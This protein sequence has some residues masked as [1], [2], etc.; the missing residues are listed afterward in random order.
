M[1]TCKNC[2][3]LQKRINELE[4]ENKKLHHAIDMDYPILHETVVDLSHVLGKINFFDLESFILFMKRAKKFSSILAD[5]AI[6]DLKSKRAR[7]EA[8]GGKEPDFE[9]LDIPFL[10][11]INR[12]TGKVHRAIEW[13]KDSM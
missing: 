7:D 1:E 11:L 6:N 5:S 4:S 3:E 2:L 9:K 13:P 8:E 12:S 10:G